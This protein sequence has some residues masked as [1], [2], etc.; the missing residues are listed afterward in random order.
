M[1]QRLAAQAPAARRCLRVSAS[2]LS[3]RR[4]LVGSSVGNVLPDYCV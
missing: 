4:V 2:P 3:G 1:Y